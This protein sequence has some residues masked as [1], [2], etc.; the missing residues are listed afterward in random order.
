MK[1]N[2][3]IL[4]SII[5]V[6]IIAPTI[7]NAQGELSKVALKEIKKKNK[8]YKKEGWKL[9]GSTRTIE[10]VL[11]D[12][13]RKLSNGGREI[14]GYASVSDSKH[15]NVLHQAAM[16]NACATYAGE[17]RKVIGQ[18]VSEMALTTEEEAEFEKFAATYQTKVE[19][20]I[21][22]EMR[23]S[24]AIIKEVSSSQLDMQVFYIVK[25]NA[26]IKAFEEI[27]KNSKVAQKYAPQIL[28]DL[29]ASF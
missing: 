16:A 11:T 6:M 24:F 15:K 9:F 19:K 10:G 8:E 7:L 23:E 29:R 1:K 4:I 25:G 14:S 12:H 2:L 5:S 26:A 13:Y 3:I 20:D 17:S 27:M 18:T 28:E 21:K 22:G